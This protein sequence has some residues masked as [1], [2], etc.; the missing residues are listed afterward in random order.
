VKQPPSRQ[1]GKEEDRD[2]FSPLAG[3]TLERR[4]AQQASAQ[5][6]SGTSPSF[7]R[8]V[9]TPLAGPAGQA[10]RRTSVTVGTLRRRVAASLSGHSDSAALDARFLVAAALS[11]GARDLALLDEK[12]VSDD[13]M[14]VAFALAERRAAGEPI[15]RIIGEREFWSLPL[16][17]TPDT[18]EPRPDTETVVSAALAA[19]AVRRDDPL[20]I[21]DLGTGSGA[22]L[23]ALLSELPQ[24]IGV[25]I[26]RAH[27]AAKTA[28]RNGRKLGLADR[29]AWVVGDWTDPI[30]GTFDMV[31]SNP[32]YIPSREIDS[33]PLEVR[34]FDPHIALDGGTDGLNG[35]RAIIPHLERIVKRDGR[36]FLE[37]GAGQAGMVAELAA[38][39]GFTAIEH[40]DLAGIERVVELTRA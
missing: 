25:G 16:G 22:I 5:V 40:R 18:L 38:G 4:R 17:L 8:S 20:T 21:L 26:D 2:A 31:V 27:G 9:P 12:P 15:G 35:Y 14:A 32:P 23:L 24:A 34:G 39:Q 30:A 29:V 36:V 37:V 11:C 3:A 19:F 6:E 7:E 1:V 10:A 28:C 13:A 33:L